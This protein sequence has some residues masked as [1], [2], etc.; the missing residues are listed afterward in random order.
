[1]GAPRPPYIPWPLPDDHPLAEM[2]RWS[3]EHQREEANDTLLVGDDKPKEL[4][5]RPGSCVFRFKHGPK[6]S[7]LKRSLCEGTPAHPVPVWV[8]STGGRPPAPVN[9]TSLE[10][11]HGDEESTTWI[12]EGEVLSLSVC[13][14]QSDIQRIRIA[15]V[16]APRSQDEAVRSYGYWQALSDGDSGDSLF[17]VE[18]FQR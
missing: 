9:V 15:L 17:V 10:V 3:V 1:M 14:P 13:P 18:I 12:S 6:P 5:F 2:L 4:G 11:A 8:P 16:E 7:D